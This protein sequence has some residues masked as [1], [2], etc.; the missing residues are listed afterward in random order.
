MK[1]T[2]AALRVRMSP[3]RLFHRGH[4]PLSPRRRGWFLHA[5]RDRVLG[6]LLEPD[7]DGALELRVVPRDHVLRSPDAGGRAGERDA[8]ARDVVEVA[9]EGALHDLD[10]V[11]GGGAAAVVTL[12]DHHALVVLL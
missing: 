4:A 7:L 6:E 11:V 3:R 1:S 12:V 8:L 10:H 2:P 9:V 5:A